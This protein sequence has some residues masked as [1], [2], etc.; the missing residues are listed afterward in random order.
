[1]RS[2]IL[3]PLDLRLKEKIPADIALDASYGTKFQQGGAMF[4]FPDAGSET[5]VEF[6]RQIVKAAEDPLF[7]IP[8]QTI[9]PKADEQE[10]QSCLVRTQRLRHHDRR[11]RMRPFGMRSERV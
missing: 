4:G 9:D 7:S 2:F 3:G 8:K 5:Q 1:M 11:N 10:R 6:E